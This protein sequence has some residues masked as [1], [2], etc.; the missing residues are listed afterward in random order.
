MLRL[1]LFIIAVSMF[2]SGWAKA[3]DFDRIV[4]EMELYAYTDFQKMKELGKQAYE[5]AGN[6]KAKQARVQL[7]YGNHFYYKGEYAKADSVFNIVS[8]LAVQGKDQKLEN[9]AALRHTVV[10]SETGNHRKAEAR[11]RNHIIQFSRQGDIKNLIDS[12]N[13]LA[14]IMIDHD[15]KRDSGLYFYNEALIQA[16]EINSEYQQAYLLNNIGLLQLNMGETDKALETFKSAYTYS[17][18]LNKVRLGAHIA[19]NIGLV[20]MRKK[21]YDESEKYFRDFLEL[22]SKAGAGKEIGVAHINLG[23]IY[24]AREEFETG[25]AYYDSALYQFDRINA[26]MFIPRAMNAVARHLITGGEYNKGIEYADSSLVMS[27]EQELLEDY[28]L[29]HRLLARAYDSLGNYKES[30]HFYKLVQ[31]LSDSM[32]QM[33]YDKTVADMAVQYD[34]Q[35]KENDLKQERANNELLKTGNELLKKKRKLD[36]IRN[37]SI[38][39]A[40]LAI[41]VLTVTIMYIRHVRVTRRKQ[42]EYSSKLLQSVENERNRIAKEL[43][44]DLGQQ[45]SMVRSRIDIGKTFNTEEMKN[46]GDSLEEVVENTR[47]I[48]RSLYPSYLRKVDLNDA[49]KTLLD[50][51]EE[52]TGLTCSYSINLNGM[53]ISDAS[54]LHVYRIIQECISNTI[55]HSGATAIKL[56]VE[57]TNNMLELEYKDNGKGIQR[58]VDMDG[59]GMMSISERVRILHGEMNVNGHK[60]KGFQINLIIDPHADS[61]S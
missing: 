29:S 51:T 21:E 48:A 19:N 14:Q 5:M 45:L 43:H 25:T 13:S 37:N 24:F 3:Q 36:E 41:L 35:E 54:K 38:I 28:I 8:K 32:Q 1:N 50:T 60:G 6:D 53:E 26:I 39:G 52:T 49:L 61:D 55:K 10:M 40:I 46:I 17:T 18:K 47:K 9:K 2:L 30:I 33:K 23:T 20:Y 4:E 16:R 31:E 22:S 34:V 11:L 15:V 42:Q 56:S 59:M 44:D 7:E 12:Y 58:K 27:L 57:H